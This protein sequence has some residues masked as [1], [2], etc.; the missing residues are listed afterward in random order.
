MNATQTEKDEGRRMNDES[1]VVHQDTPAERLDALRQFGAK[2]KLQRMADAVRAEQA[3]G[4]LKLLIQAMGYKTGQSYYLRS[5]LYSLWNGK[6]AKLINVLNL[7][8]ELRDA[9]LNV[10]SGFG[11]E[12]FFYNE[13]SNAL[14]SAGLFDWFCEEGD[15]Q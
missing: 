12:H 6:A 8:R 7:D 4:S 1:L 2:L 11:A 15:A 9:L 13:I 14:V 3:Q 10:I 5:L